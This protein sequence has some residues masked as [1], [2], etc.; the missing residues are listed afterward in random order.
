MKANEYSASEKAAI[1]EEAGKEGVQ[2]TCRK[3]G[4]SEHSYR[5]WKELLEQGGIAA[6]EPK[7]PSVVSI[8]PEL[9]HLRRENAQLKRLLTDKELLLLAKEELLKK[10]S[11]RTMTVGGNHE[12]AENQWR[13]IPVPSAALT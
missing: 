4:I 11:S 2:R 8:A 3:H 10:S 9:A 5:R 13:G 6:L 7:R 12:I 1:V